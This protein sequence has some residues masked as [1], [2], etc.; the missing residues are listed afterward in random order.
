M[1]HKVC[2]LDL[3]DCSTHVTVVVAAQPGNLGGGI[4]SAD[5]VFSEDVLALR[6]V[7]ILEEKKYFI[8]CLKF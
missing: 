1:A 3:L 5:I 8:L 6:V 7:V 2:D 4:T